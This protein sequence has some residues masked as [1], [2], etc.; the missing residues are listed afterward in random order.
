M[1]TR[2]ARRAANKE[3][4]IYSVKT[5]F[6]KIFTDARLAEITLRA[7]QLVTPI[8]IEANA[9]ANLHVL[10]C[11]ET[12]GAVPKLDQTFFS[13]CMYAVSHAT[14]RQAVQCNADKNASLAASHG[15]YSQQLPQTHQKPER[16][17]YL[18]DVSVAPGPMLCYHGA[19]CL[20]CCFCSLYNALCL[21]DIGCT[22]C[23]TAATT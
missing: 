1:A 6:K 18:K 9:L 5:G 15:L 10:R 17:T 14:G 23:L 7:V 20:S 16:P 3:G 22:T 12:N 13:N 19:S 4:S 8:L 21:A 11:L 2:Q